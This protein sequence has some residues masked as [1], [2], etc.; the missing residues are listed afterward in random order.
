M[1]TSTSRLLTRNPS[2]A[3]LV[4]QIM[5]YGRLNI[6]PSP[7]CAFVTVL[8]TISGQR[9]RNTQRI[10]TCLSLFEL[11]SRACGVA[12]RSTATDV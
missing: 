7:F 6:R 3:C 9:V 4:V 1:Y 2:C 11:Y 8:L 5:G 10:C 12:V